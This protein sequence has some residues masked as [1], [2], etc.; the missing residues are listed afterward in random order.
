MGSSARMRP[1]DQCDRAHR[2]GGAPHL[3]GSQRL[4]TPAQ[5]VAFQG[6][7]KGEPPTAFGLKA[8]G[9]T[10]ADW[11]GR[12]DRITLGGTIGASVGAVKDGADVAVSVEVAQAVNGASAA[13]PRRLSVSA[14]FVSRSR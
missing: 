8:R 3:G 13:R 10:P 14:R 4:G 2:R 12:F 5:T 11:T 6:R 7:S 1:N 9:V